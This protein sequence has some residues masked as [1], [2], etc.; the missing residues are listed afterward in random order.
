[1]EERQ[2]EK[3][4]EIDLQSMKLIRISALSHSSNFEFLSLSPSSRLFL[5]KTEN[6]IAAEEEEASREVV[7][8]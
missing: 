8:S 6:R 2:R 3:R 7:G 4:S 1:M 5:G